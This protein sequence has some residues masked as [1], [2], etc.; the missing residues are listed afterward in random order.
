M[1][2]SFCR[3]ARQV[4]SRAAQPRSTSAV[5]EPERRPSDTEPLTLS[6]RTLQ[7]V[8][9]TSRD[10]SDSSRDASAVE[11]LTPDAS[12]PESSSFPARYKLVL[13]CM[14][15]FIICNMVRSF[16]STC[17]LRTQLRGTRL[18]WL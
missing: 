9:S 10:V 8:P 14:S 5:Q 2:G 11:V 16:F 12:T 4:A 1:R 17:I 15:A 13:S 18:P 7:N 6:T 3:V